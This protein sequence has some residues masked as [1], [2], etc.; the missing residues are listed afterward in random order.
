MIETR[1]AQ[2]QQWIRGSGMQ[3]DSKPQAVQLDNAADVDC[4]PRH[5]CIIKCIIHRGTDDLTF[6]GLVIHKRLYFYSNFGQACRNEGFYSGHGKGICTYVKQFRLLE[7]LTPL[8][9][10]VFI[11][12]WYPRRAL[13]ALFGDSL[14]RGRHLVAWNG[15]V[16]TFGSHVIIHSWMGFSVFSSWKAMAQYFIEVYTNGQRPEIS[17]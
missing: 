1:P 17:D 12:S 13:A 8:L 16:F 11:R 2:R 5:I 4:Q 10:R 15:A 14:P 9:S 3:I 7:P 6:N